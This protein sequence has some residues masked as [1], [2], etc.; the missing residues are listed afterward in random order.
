MYPYKYEVKCMYSNAVVEN[1]G[2]ADTVAEAKE[3]IKAFKKRGM[4]NHGCPALEY[5]YQKSGD[6]YPDYIYRLGE[7]IYCEKYC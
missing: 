1:L 4:Y 2:G 6:Y 3:L 5:W 7:K